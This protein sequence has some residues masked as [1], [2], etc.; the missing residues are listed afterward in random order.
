MEPQM[1]IRIKELTVDVKFKS[2]YLQRLSICCTVTIFF[3][4]EA[5]FRFLMLMKFRSG[6][7]YKYEDL[8]RKLILIPSI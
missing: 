4:I 3:Y 2:I 6:F 7:T 5:E 1:P 8:L